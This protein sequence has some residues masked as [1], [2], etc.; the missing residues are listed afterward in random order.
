[1]GPPSGTYKV[2]Q[3]RQCVRQDISPTTDKPYVQFDGLQKQALAHQPVV[4]IA[5]PI[6]EN[7][8][9]AVNK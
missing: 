2:L 5:H 7:Q 8:R 9:A 3:A 4:G 1:M 6:K